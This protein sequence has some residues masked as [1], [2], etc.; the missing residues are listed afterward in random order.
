MICLGSLVIFLLLLQ[1]L[2]QLEQMVCS[3]TSAANICRL[4]EHERVINRP[5]N[6]TEIRQIVIY[7]LCCCGTFLF[8]FQKILV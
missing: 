3:Q 2:Y 8:L 1:W 4:R 6:Q 7:S 5:V